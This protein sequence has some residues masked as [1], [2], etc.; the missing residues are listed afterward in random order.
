MQPES[1]GRLVATALALAAAAASSTA[2]A[3]GSE[4]PHKGVEQCFSSAE[5]AQP[6]MRG[7]ELQAAQRLLRECAR[8]ECPKAARTD[9][10][11]WLDTVTRALP[12]VVFAAREEGGAAPSRPVADVGVVVDGQLVASRLD[13]AALPLDPGPHRMRFEHA[14]FDP[15]EQRVELREGEHRQ[16]D[17]VFRRTDG[18]PEPAPTP[19]PPLRVAPRQASVPVFAYVLA[20]TGVVA[21][22]AGIVLEAIGLS[23]RAGLVSSC[24]PTR[25]CDPS[26]VD[27]ARGRVLAGD[28]LLGTS[29]LLLGGAAYL[30]FTRDSGGRTTSGALRVRLGAVAGATGLA[31]EGDL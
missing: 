14:G 21:L 5:A 16:V 26:A 23:D 3:Q 20:G 29:A 28:V 10:R 7:H 25:S 13:G 8:D 18:L 11:A 27:A 15:V 12:T 24:K 31:L 30:Y 17:V 9:C 19:H 6:L 1:F 2:S 4:E 22:G